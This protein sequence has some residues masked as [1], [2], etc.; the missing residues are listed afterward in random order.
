MATRRQIRENFYAELET[1]AGGFVAAGDIG[2]E[3]PNEDETLPA[4]VHNDNYREVPMNTNTGPVAVQ[5]DSAG[6]QA[7]V[8]SEVMEAQF[9][10]LVVSDDEDLKE[11]IYEAVRSH[12][13]NFKFPT[14]DAS[15]IH[16]DAYRVEVNDANSDDTENRDPPARGDRLAINVGFERYY[17]RDTT[18]AESVTLNQDADN[19][20]TTD[21][22]YTTT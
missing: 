20:G 16:A 5:T 21:E 12:F 17:T 7:E 22:T 11:D 19:D 8:Y 9:S 3:Y 1:A 6:V 18:P 15:E 10:I 14:R 4:I 2:Q 13:G